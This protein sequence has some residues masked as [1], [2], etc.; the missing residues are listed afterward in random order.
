MNSFLLLSN[1]SKKSL[2]LGNNP[3]SILKNTGFDVLWKKL[4]NS[5]KLTAEAKLI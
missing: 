3:V 1:S 5:N 2:T 4:T